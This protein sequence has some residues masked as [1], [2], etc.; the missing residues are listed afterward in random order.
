MDAENSWTLER[1]QAF[2]KRFRLAK[3]TLA[4]MLHIDR[5]TI[6]HWDNRGGASWLLPEKYWARLSE[7]EKRLYSMQEENPQ[8][9]FVYADICAKA[10][11]SRADERECPLCAETIKKRAIFCKHC[12]STIRRGR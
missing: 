2:L 7:F 8:G 4:K 12:R 10:L 3:T 6:T 11:T 1:L 5:S 9:V